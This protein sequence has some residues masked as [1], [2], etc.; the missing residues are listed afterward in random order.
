MSCVELG[1][2]LNLLCTQTSVKLVKKILTFNDDCN[3]I[4]CRSHTRT[5]SVFKPTE[6]DTDAKKRN[7]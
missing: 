3:S 6:R 5:T 4:V 1:A 2:C 7:V